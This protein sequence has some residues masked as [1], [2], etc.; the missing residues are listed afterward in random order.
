MYGFLFYT[1]VFYFDAFA[2]QAISSMDVVACQGQLPQ[3]GAL[4]L[5]EEPR[6]LAM[7]DRDAFQALDGLLDRIVTV[8]EPCDWLALLKS[9]RS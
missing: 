7:R 4:T 5:W 2:V 6:P 1:N 9:R 3:P 8:E